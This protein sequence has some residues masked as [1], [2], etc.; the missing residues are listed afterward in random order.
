MIVSVAVP[1]LIARGDG[2]PIRFHSDRALHAESTIGSAIVL[3]RIASDDPYPV[4]IED[5]ARAVA[6]TGRM[7]ARIALGVMGV[8]LLVLWIRSDPASPAAWVAVLLAIPALGPLAS[9]QFL[10]WP[11]GLVALGSR[12]ALIAFV[13]AAVLSGAMFSGPLEPSE[14]TALAILTG[15]RNVALLAAFVLATVAALH[16]SR[17]SPAD[18]RP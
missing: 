15:A 4:V 1:F 18:L 7:P 2:D 13:G 12:R 6:D 9:P 11:L 8:S 10:L 14:G 17:P 3:A 16:R 5:N